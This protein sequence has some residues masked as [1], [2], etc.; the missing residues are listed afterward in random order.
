MHPAR[1]KGQLTLAAHEY[2]EVVVQ[3]QFARGRLGLTRALSAD[4]DMMAVVR[5]LEKLL[6]A[7]I[8]TE[9]MWLSRRFSI[10]IAGEITQA[11]SHASVSGLNVLLLGSEV[12]G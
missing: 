1:K 2:S 12:S 11:A 6:R 9:R 7:M 3:T 8:R 4:G 10:S 5:Q